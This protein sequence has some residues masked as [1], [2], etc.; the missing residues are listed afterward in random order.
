MGA[1]RGGSG[2]GEELSSIPLH[3][4]AAYPQGGQVC[5]WQCSGRGAP[6]STKGDRYPGGWQWGRKRVFLSDVGESV[7]SVMDSHCDRL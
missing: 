5:G 7:L 1:L 3:H 2:T 6:S 4:T